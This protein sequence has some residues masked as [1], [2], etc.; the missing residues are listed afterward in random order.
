MKTFNHKDDDTLWFV[1]WDR[2]G[3]HHAKWSKQSTEN[4]CMIGIRQT[5]CQRLCSWVGVH[6]P[7]LVACRIP[8]CTKDTITQVEVPW[9]YQMEFF[10]FNDLFGYCA[11]PCCPTLRLW[12]A[13]PYLRISQGCLDIFMGYFLSNNSKECN[14]DLA[15][16]NCLTASDGQMRICM[17]HC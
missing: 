11:Q 3:N 17:D 7:L 6:I 14:P 10:T 16:G 12:K 15:T 5:K 1:Q 2:I 8:S 4:K 9:R 13:N